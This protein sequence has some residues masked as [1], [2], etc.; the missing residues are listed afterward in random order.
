MFLL[1][2]GFVIFHNSVPRMVLQ[3]MNINLACPEEAFQATS[4]EDFLAAMER[5]PSGLRP[6]LL[7]DCVRYLCSE[8]PDD[9]TTMDY[10]RHASELNLFTIATGERTD[11]L[12]I[13]LSLS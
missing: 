8:D 4:P 5:H 2:S 10:L 7:T 6:P 11:P 13:R 12:P 1:D 9:T 3:E